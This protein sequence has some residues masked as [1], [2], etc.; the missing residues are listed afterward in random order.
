MRD[1]PASRFPG[2]SSPRRFEFKLHLHETA[3][4]MTDPAT[5]KTLLDTHGADPASVI[6]R[7]TVYGFHALVA[8]RWSKGRVFLAGDA[9]H[10]TPPFAGQGM[11]SGIRDAHNIAWKLA[12]VHAGRASPGILA[13]YQTERRPH[14]RQMIDLALRMGRIMGPSSPWRGLAT[15]CLFRGLSLWPPAKSYLAEMRY[16]PKPFFRQGFLIQPQQRRFAG[17]VG[18][19]IPQP[20]LMLR[21]GDRVRLD[22]VLG[23]DFGLLLIGGVP[24][25]TRRVSAIWSG[26]P[27][28]LAQVA[29]TDQDELSISGLVLA[30]DPDGAFSEMLGSGSALCLLVRPDRYVMAAFAPSEAAQ[31]LA[32]LHRLLGGAEPVPGAMS[33]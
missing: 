19:L 13:S 14:V 21:N 23:D 32:S 27:V 29:I 8:P 11:N 15:R 31:V 12:E 22:D 6:R 30:S 28:T 10:L 16:K 26:A 9:C 18:R 24:S 5:V 17:L 3:E 25:E 1:G 7:K 2:Q 33:A 20:K 4:Q